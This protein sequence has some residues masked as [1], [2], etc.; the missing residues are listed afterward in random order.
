MLENIGAR[1]ADL[2]GR[3][4]LVTGGSRGI[5]AATCR[6]LAANGVRVAVNGR[7]RTAVD[8]VVAEIDGQGGAALAAPGDVTDEAALADVREVIETAYGPVDI[9]AAFAGGSGAPAP[10][11]QLGASRWRAVLETDLTSLYLT[12]AEFLPGMIDR[13]AGS[14]ITMSSAA[15]R[16]PSEANIAYAVAKA[17][18][19]M[20]ARHLAKEVGHHHVRVNC[21]APSAVRNER[22]ERHLTTEQLAGLAAAFPLGRIGRPD[23]IAQAALFL[24][25]DCSSWITGV[26]LDL[27][28]GRVI[29]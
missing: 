10:T 16:Q 23:D 9:L 18:V 8:A 26:T 12:V 27:S 25:S 5:G 15:G 24:A 21:L 2:D 1:Y 4:A 19:T 7:D 13:G 3:V 11:A 28:G 6:A 22:M 14:I 29:V 20:F 17:G